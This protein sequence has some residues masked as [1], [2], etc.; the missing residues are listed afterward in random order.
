MSRDLANRLTSLGKEII[1][2][3]RNIMS[4]REAPVVLSEKPGI[5]KSIQTVDVMHPSP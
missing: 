4:T 5:H 1:S 2:I 3:R